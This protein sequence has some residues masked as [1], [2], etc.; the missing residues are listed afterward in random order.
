MIS[1]IVAIKLVFSSF[2]VCINAVKS[3]IF[4]SIVDLVFSSFAILVLIVFNCS[5]KDTISLFKF[6]I[7]C[8]DVAIVLL[9]VSIKFKF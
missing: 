8:S 4:F 1:S 2:L 9:L 3:E 7:F 6:V 5:F